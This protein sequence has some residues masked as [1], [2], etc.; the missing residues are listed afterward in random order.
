MIPDEEIALMLALSRAFA[1]DT[2]QAGNQHEH[3]IVTM[4]CQL[5][6]R[7]PDLYVELGRGNGSSTF[8]AAMALA[9]NRHGRVVSYDLH[10]TG[11]D[12]LSR[13]PIVDERVGDIRTLS[14]TD[15]DTLA[16]GCDRIAVLVDAHEQ[17]GQPVAEVLLPFVRERR[18]IAW[19]VMFHDVL[20]M[21]EQTLFDAFADH[22]QRRRPFVSP[23]LEYAAIFQAFDGMPVS[24]F[25]E[26]GQPYHGAMRALGVAVRKEPFR[27]GVQ[28]W[29]P[30]ADRELID[31]LYALHPASSIAC[32]DMAATR[33]KVPG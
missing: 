20:N 30:D 13:F 6:N 11:H 18:D 33:A 32:I 4:Y 9:A 16:T 2:A 12:L 23:Y 19:F 22:Y 27:A 10:P 8:V 3:D 5:R 15:W 26:L 7:R 28:Q 14:S 1:A 31:S 25:A 24:H 17:T 21:P 29:K